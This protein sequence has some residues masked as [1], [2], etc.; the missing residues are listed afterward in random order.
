MVGSPRRTPVSIVCVFNDP[1]V[2]RTCL[3]RSVHA[4]RAEAPD[5][6]Y[7]PVDNTDGQ[8]TSAGAALNHGARRARHRVVVLVHQDVFLHSLAALE[9]AAAALEDDP[10]TGLVGAVGVTAAGSV[11][12]LVRDRVVMIGRPS[13]PPV[14]VDS[15]D[16]VLF[17]IERDRLLREPL[18]E[19]PDLAWHAYAVEYGARVRSRGLRVVSANL[20]LTHNSMTTNLDRLVDAH[21]H[22]ARL[23]PGMLP[24]RTTCGIVRDRRQRSRWRTILRRRHGA[25]VWMSESLTALSLARR[26]GG[27]TRDVVLADIRL[28]IDDALQ[29]LGAPG[30]EILNLD[31]P[32][33]ETR[34]WA[35]DGLRRRGRDVSAAGA[36]VDDALTSLGGDRRD[37]ALL[38]T[39]I[40]AAAMGRLAPALRRTPHVV[41]LTRDIG[42]WVLCHP[43]AASL[44]PLWTTRR[45]APFALRPRADRPARAAGASITEPPR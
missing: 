37:R 23:Y 2:R 27:P 1:E 17:M 42:A 15:L 45:S 22:V 21:A 6:E 18:S 5:T 9:Q 39:G 4:G 41:G 30:V 20:P 11:A 19:H 33:P 26:H 14:P 25:A 24:M 3:D 16:E 35:V 13:A 43:D 7:L 38:V 31:A 10:V 40:G 32:G 44:R 28:L 36:T 29:A 12:G 8:F 34:A